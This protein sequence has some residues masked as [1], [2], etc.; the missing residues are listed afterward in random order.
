MRDPYISISTNA[1][2]LVD[3]EGNIVLATGALY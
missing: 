2:S 3:N 1:Q